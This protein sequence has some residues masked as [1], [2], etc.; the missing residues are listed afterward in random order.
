[1]IAFVELVNRGDDDGSVVVTFEH[2]GIEPVGHV[3]LKV[4]ANSR[5]WRTWARTRMI[6]KPGSWQA[7]VRTPDGKELARQ[8]FEVAPYCASAHSAPTKISHTTPRKCQYCTARRTPSWRELE[9]SFLAARRATSA[10]GT[11]PPTT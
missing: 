11:R 10:S 1:M 7:V 4:P 6:K 3:H 5:R 2:E 8:S 9:Y